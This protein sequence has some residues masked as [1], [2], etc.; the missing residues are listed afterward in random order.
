MKSTLGQEPRELSMK[1]I[2][3]YPLEIRLE[4]VQKMLLA[5][6]GQLT[7]DSPLIHPYPQ[8][9]PM[10]AVSIMWLALCSQVAGPEL[11]M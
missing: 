4:F 1:E 3:L 2:T 5:I 9:S 10:V 6:S 11:G 7:P 8:G